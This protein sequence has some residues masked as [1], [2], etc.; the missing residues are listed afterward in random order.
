MGVVHDRTPCSVE[1]PPNVCSRGW[2]T[3][4]RSIHPAVAVASHQGATGHPASHNMKRLVVTSPS[5]IA[6]M[7]TQ[8]RERSHDGDSAQPTNRTSGGSPFSARDSA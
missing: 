6:T 4:A 8:G 3:Y 7:L 2:R 1:A 5:A